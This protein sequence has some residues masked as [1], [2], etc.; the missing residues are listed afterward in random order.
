MKGL[1]SNVA[2][3]ERGRLSLVALKQKGRLSNVALERMCRLSDDPFAE[4]GRPGLVALLVKGFLSNEAVVEKVH[5]SKVTLKRE[6]RLTNVVVA[7][8]RDQS[9]RDFVTIWLCS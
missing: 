8:V 4:K 7:V 1:L 5:H 2:L 9:G 6:A 3:A